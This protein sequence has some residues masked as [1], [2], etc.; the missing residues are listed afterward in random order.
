MKKW[1]L[2]I[3]TIICFALPFPNWIYSIVKSIQ[4]S[5]NCTNYL[6]LSAEANSIVLAERHLT[7]AIDYLERNEITSGQARFFVKYPKNDIGLWYENLKTAQ[8]QL[9]KMIADGDYNELE[10]SNML[11]KLRETLL[12]EECVVLPLCVSLSP[13]G[14]LLLW[15]NLTMWL[16]WILGGFMC[17]WT[18]EEFDY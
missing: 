13:N 9:Q 6:E 18:W 3:L 7:T 1:L 11:M 15:L 14:T 10:Q 17:W 8:S 4:F 2:L 12:D 5:A 16:V